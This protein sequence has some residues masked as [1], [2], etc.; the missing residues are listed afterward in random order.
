MKR[1]L[2]LPAGVVLAC[3]L[4]QAKV[5]IL[6]YWWENPMPYQEPP[7]PLTSLSAQECGACHQEIYRE[8]KLSAHAHALSDLQFQ[9]ELKKSPETAWLCMNCHT[10][11]ENQLPTITV[12]VRN[13]STHQPIVRKNARFDA[14]LREEAITCAVCHVRDGFVIGPYGDSK[15]PHPVRK[16]TA[17]LTETGCTQCHQATASYTDTLVCSFDTG[18]EWKASPYAKNEQSCTHCHMPAVERSIAVG[19]PKRA[20]RRHL[21]IG[22]KIPKVIGTNAE[23]KKYYDLFRPGLTVDIL[24]AVRT[25]SRAVVA[26]KLKN[27]YAGH[28][29]PTGDPERYILVHVKVND[30]LRTIRIGQEW[31]WWPKARK[32]SD[33]RMKPL[34]ERIEK[35]EFPLASKAPATLKVTVRNVRLNEKN[36]RYHNLIGKYPL[37][38]E[39]LSLPART[40]R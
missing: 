36:A 5:N 22:S 11:L 3:L 24:S 8:W 26:L 27:A 17:L 31:E 23:L 20:S 35:L 30:Q 28:L 38:A 12:G 13:K 32:L 4:L 1:K 25:G 33:N 37:D 39:V 15:A 16:D 19:G 9:A 29:L 10:P 2:L 6:G 14:T 18:G 21:F 40:L 34:E 7:K